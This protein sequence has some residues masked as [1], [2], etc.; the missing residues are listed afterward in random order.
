MIALNETASGVSFSVRVQPGAKR[1]V[2]LGE[3]GEALKIALTAPPVD[4]RAN[5]ACVEFLAGLLDIPQSSVT[6]VSGHNR[7]NKVVRVA[8]LSSSTLRQRLEQ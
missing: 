1:N 3:F 6:I 5:E 4:G 7:R 8:G 2:V